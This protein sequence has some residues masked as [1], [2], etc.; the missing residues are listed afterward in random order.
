[1]TYLEHIRNFSDGQMAYF[2]NAIQPEITIFSLAMSRALS[3]KVNN[4]KNYKGPDVY[5]GLSG[6]ARYMMSLLYKDYD[7]DMRDL[8]DCRNE[9]LD[10][11]HDYASGNDLRRVVGL[12]QKERELAKAP[13]DEAALAKEREP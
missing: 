13:E 11:L 10:R 1:M 2:L 12:S 3:D 9:S 8:E 6:D 4:G 7:K 5:C